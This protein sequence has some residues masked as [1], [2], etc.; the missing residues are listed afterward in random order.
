MAAGRPPPMEKERGI[1]TA[2]V[3]QDNISMMEDVKPAKRK[4]DPS[5]EK[6]SK[7]DKKSKKLKLSEPPPSIEIPD[8]SLPSEKPKKRK[9]DSKDE[10]TKTPKKLKK[11]KSTKSEPEELEIDI[12]AP[13]PPSKKALRLLKK[14]KPIPPL[15]STSQPP[16]TLTTTPATPATPDT[17]HPSRRN[18]V[19]E[20]PHAEF[21]VWIGNLSYQSDVKALRGWLVRGDNR[22]KD[23][24]ITRLNLPLNAQGLSKGYG[25]GGRLLM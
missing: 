14:G 22:V 10:S 9:R 24:D 19:K 3:F 17:T 25:L 12:T 13:N 5:K 8:A 21:S 16:T 2:K 11:E 6:S 23:K 18:L 1:F 4:K 15:P 7:K 20:I